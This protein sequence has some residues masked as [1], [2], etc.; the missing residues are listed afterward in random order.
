MWGAPGALGGSGGCMGHRDVCYDCPLVHL[1]GGLGYERDEEGDEE[2][3]RI[4]M[5][6]L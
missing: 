4:G 2:V 6:S 1:Y 5:V 3:A